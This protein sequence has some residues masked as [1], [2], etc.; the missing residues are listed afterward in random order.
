[1]K[2]KFAMKYLINLDSY[3]ACKESKYD[4]LL[5]NLNKLHKSNEKNILEKKT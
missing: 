3:I 1:M 2:I 5:A 4:H